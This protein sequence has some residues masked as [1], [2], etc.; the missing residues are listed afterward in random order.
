M[1]NT[2]L[3]KN[4]IDHKIISISNKRQMTIPQKYFEA[5][6]FHKEAECVLQK[7]SIIIRPLQ[8][9]TGGEF[10]EQILADLI[11]QGYSGN[12]LLKKFKEINNKI[13]SAI[14][15]LLKEADQI[16]AGKKKGATMSDVFG[17]KDK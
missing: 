2:E 5:L 1:S 16:A 3:K 6:E 15:E 4:E 12:K 17:L 14:K 8:K 9:N 13:P 11:S 10:A 7:N